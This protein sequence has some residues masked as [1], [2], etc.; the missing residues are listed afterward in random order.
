[1]QSPAIA[2]LAARYAALLRLPDVARIL[3]LTFVAR[4]PVG[5]LTLSMLL[6]VRAMTGSFAV[7]GST[8]GAYLTASALSS[9]FVGRWVDRRGPVAPL[10]VTGVLS[11]VMGL[12]I[13]P[14]TYAVAT[15]GL[16]LA[17]K[18]FVAL[19]IGGFGSLWGGLVGGL[20]IGLVEAFSI[21]YLGSEFGNVSVFVVLLLVLMVRPTG[22]FGRLRER[23]V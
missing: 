16:S 9:P 20:V 17:L 8:V 13:G 7:A 5:T 6:H 19:A 4:M 3:A 15:L 21:R 14:K 10:A 23:V 1:M 18:G 12:F 11:G 22:L 2:A